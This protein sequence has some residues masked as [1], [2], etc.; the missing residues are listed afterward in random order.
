L[1]V[2]PTPGELAS[3][4]FL[5]PIG[6]MRIRLA[7]A[8]GC[9]VLGLALWVFAPVPVVF[10]GLGLVLL[11]HLPL[12]VRTQSTAPGG[13]TPFHE[14]VW[15][16]VEDDWMERVR[17][18]EKR[19]EKWDASPWD[20]SSGRGCLGC[21]GVLGLAALGF[22]GA[23]VL[24]G[25]QTAVRVAGGVGALLLP[26][27]L[28]GMRSVWNPSELRLKGEALADARKVAEREAEDELEPVPLLALREGRRGKYPVDA[29]LML[30][31]VDDDGSGFIGVQV[32]VALNNVKGKDYPYLYCVVLGKEG[33]RLPPSR[34]AYVPD[35]CT[36]R[37]VYELGAGDD[38]EYLVVRRHADKQGG[39]HTR[40]ND[41]RQIV[42]VALREARAA[43]RENLEN[44][45][46]ESP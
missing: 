18:L 11:G 2:W 34:S 40:S 37:I 7:L 39:W 33:F 41:V 42:E 17:D 9:F 38:V 35:G 15:A 10:L 16:P 27:W 1:S 36:I 25:N 19:G 43:R 22:F 30:R 13:A 14:E 3:L 29:R 28:N 8:A 44:P 45:P 46:E 31:P 23:G 24:F 26:V 4:R 6:G 5:L 21:L 12:W 32:Q 20:V